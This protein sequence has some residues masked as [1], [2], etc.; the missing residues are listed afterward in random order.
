MAGFVA[1][2]YPRPVLQE[3]CPRCDAEWPNDAHICAACGFDRAGSRSSNER[4][5]DA[6][7]PLRPIDAAILVL[8]TMALAIVSF[9]AGFSLRSDQAAPDRV[10]EPAI[11]EGANDVPVAMPGRV[12]FAER[13]GD[14]LELE[15][16]RTEFTRDDTIA[17]RAEFEEPPAADELKVVIAWYS[18]RE[19][20][21][22]SE[23]TVAVRDAELKVV[24]RDEIP[25][26][27]LVPTA[28][29]YS[30]TYYSGDTKLAEGIFELLPRDR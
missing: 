15:S 30:V 4:E 5:R 14:S 28:G 23:S 13:L 17:W 10:D 24:A 26:A 8:A 11:A 21:R 27:A 29:L 22:V 7:R 9:G 1:S 6:P 16:Y 12:L 18:V 19:T 25:L 2:T 20:M 3:L